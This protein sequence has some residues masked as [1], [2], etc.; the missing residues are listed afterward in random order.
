MTTFVRNNPA[1]TVRIRGSKMEMSQFKE[2]LVEQ[3]RKKMTIR[4]YENDICLFARWFQQTNGQELTA[5]T[6][7]AIDVR[8]Y[9]QFMLLQQKA[10]P[11]T[12]NRRLAASRMYIKWALSEKI[13]NYNP[14]ENIKGV[15]EQDHAPRWLSRQ[16]QSALIREIEKRMQAA[17]TPTRKFEAI[18]DHAILLLLLN[19]GIRVSEL[20]GLQADDLV[21]SE[22]KGQIIIRSG[23][24]QK[25]RT[26]PLNESSRKALRQYLEA[27]PTGL[28]STLFTGMRGG[29][30]T[31]AVQDMLKSL[32]HMARVDVSPHML[33]HSFAKNLVNSDVSLEKVAMLLGHSSLNTT[34]LYTTPSS[35]DL[36]KA[37]GLL[38]G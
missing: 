34:R 8:E 33:R 4:S 26:V 38:D 10:K 11:A 37:V 12:I 9:K 35:Y 21:L 28:P 7:T 24:G 17:Q 18:R 6:I 14:I 5:S 1:K 3:D 22:R 32:G 13:I 15:R 30:Q 23:K 27:R 29:L 25:T 20:C 2:Y 36:E 16:Q 31:R 19:S